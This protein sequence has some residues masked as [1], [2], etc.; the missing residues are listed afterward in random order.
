M[1]EHVESARGEGNGEFGAMG[2][3]EARDGGETHFSRNHEG[4]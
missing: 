4:W 2:G 1:G 3:V